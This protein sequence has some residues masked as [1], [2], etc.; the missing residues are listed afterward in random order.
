MKEINSFFIQKVCIIYI[1]IWAISPILAYGLAYRLLAIILSLVWLFVESIRPNNIFIKPSKLVVY[2]LIFLGFQIT[3]KLIVPDQFSFI[4][5]FQI[6]IYFLFGLM[7]ES[8]RK[9]NYRDIHQIILLV[10]LLMPVWMT[11]TNIAVANMT[12]SDGAVVTRVLAKSSDE[13]KMLTSLGVGGYGMVYFLVLYLPCVFYLVR[14]FNKLKFD[15]LRNRNFLLFLL[16][17]NYLLGIY[18]IFKADYVIAIFLT[19]VGIGFSL[20]YNAQSKLKQFVFFGTGISFFLIVLPLFILRNINLLIELFWGTSLHRKLVDI[21]ISLVSGSSKGTVSDRTDRY[22]RSWNYLL[23]NFI[24]GTL[25]KDNLGKHSMILDTFA[26][27]G[28]F[29]GTFFCVVLLYI[30]FRSNREHV[31]KNNLHITVGL[32]LFLICLLNNIGAIMGVAVFFV[33]PGVLMIVKNRKVR[34]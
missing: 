11:T 33:Y 23:D 28:V 32:L 4:S 15:S 10:M 8:L 7:G 14:N 16:L 24:T 29:I 6:Y 26:Q 27:Y 13:A 5:Y 18:T 17:V 2:T 30:F 25:K 19:L 34:I 31:Q 12:A 3:M 22:L 20:F 9:R 1:I 21:Q